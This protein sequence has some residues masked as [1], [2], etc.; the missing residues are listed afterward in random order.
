MTTSRVSTSATAKE[1]R[2]PIELPVLQDLRMG[3]PAPDVGDASSAAALVADP[4]RAGIIRILRDGPVC[5][6]EMASALGVRQNNVSNHLAKLREGG[7]VRPSTV[8]ADTRRVYYER[9]HEACRRALDAL[10][11]VLR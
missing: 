6:C 11:E 5:V 2:M 3:L 10:G 1:R 4:V 9:N 7:L 8:V